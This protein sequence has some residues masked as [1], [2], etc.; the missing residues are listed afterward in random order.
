MP[1]NIYSIHA[2]TGY[3]EKTII[4]PNEYTSASKDIGYPAKFD[5]YVNKL[6]IAEGSASVT[7]SRAINELIGSKLYLFHRPLVNADGSITPI[8]ASAGTIDTTSTN[9]RQGYIVFSSVPVA[10]FTV[11]YIAAPDCETVT[12]INALQDS[13]M[14]LQ[15]ILGPS[16]LTG[17]AGLRNL[18]YGIFDS[19]SDSTAS[20]VAQNAIY[21]SHLDRDIVI[22]SS[23]D[24][25]LAL[26]RGSG[27]L[28]QIG[29]S[30]DAVALNTTGFRVYHSDLTKTLNVSLN[31]RTGDLVTYK[32]TL[33]GAGPAFIGGSEWPNYSGIVFSTQLTG[34]FYSGAMLKV[35]GD[36]AVMGQIKSVGAITVVTTTGTTSQILGD[37]LVSDELTVLGV[38]HLVGDVETNNISV[39]N[40]LTINGNIVAGNEIG[41]GGN[42]QSLVDN[43]DCSEVAWTYQT[44]AKKVYPNSVISGPIKLTSNPPVKTLTTVFGTLGPSSLVGDQTIIT[45]SLNAN[46]G[47][48]G[49]HPCIL[50]LLLN[51]EAVSGFFGG[52]RGTL[53]GVWSPGLLD[54][55]STHIRMLNGNSE[56]MVQ[57]IYGYTIEQTGTNTLTRLNVFCPEMPSSIPATSN[58][59]MMYNPGN[60]PYKFIYTTDGTT[61]TFQVSGSSTVPL[62]IAFDD[63]VRILNSTTSSLSMKTALEYSVSGFAAPATGVC[64]IIA[65][66]NGTDPENAPVFKARA[67]PYR[68]ANETIIGEVV[69]SLSGTNWTVREAVSYRPNGFYDSA[70]VPIVQS[71]GVSNV[72]GRAVPGLTSASTSPLRVYF[73]HDL[74]PD[75]DLT[76]VTADLYLASYSTVLPSGR[77]NYNQTYMHSLAGQDVRN[78][79]GLSGVFIHVPLGAKRVSSAITERDASIFYMDSR[80]MGV[81]LS[82]DLMDGFPTGTSSYTN[83]PSYL[84]LVIKR[85]A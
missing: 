16:N 42:G 12:H 56:G 13:V 50:Q 44:L 51:V 81:D 3:S 45:G 31:E 27:H 80:L 33:S 61:P 77:Y 15:K 24:P 41:T 63:H 75:V 25:T 64:Y 39:D 4:S 32:G 58:N 52:T 26:A 48:S 74:G 71:I 19:P 11:S 36:V 65:D 54:P 55:G 22:S 34:S 78:N 23:S 10:D 21:L 84:R 17:Y 73:A 20:G 47:P 76:K 60:V 57:P 14:E 66:S 35:H 5:V 43:L 82:P 6:S 59:W 29:N 62:K 9:A 2:P 40:T 85:D 79:N 69:A 28:I 53:S 8:T 18:K 37:F 46:A 68:R 83:T 1:S 72:S 30:T 67:T 38:S 7:E 49:A 70:W